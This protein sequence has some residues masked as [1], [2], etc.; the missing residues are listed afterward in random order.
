[1]ASVA[2]VPVETNPQ[3]LSGYGP[4]FTW[5][6]R[7]WDGTPQMAYDFYTATSKMIKHKFPAIQAGGPA[8]GASS[9]E[10]PCG[11]TTQ[12]SQTSLGMMWIKDF[13]Q[14][15]KAHGAPLDLFSFHYG[16]GQG[17]STDSVSFPMIYQS[18]LQAI[19]FVGGFWNIPV[20]THGVQIP[21]CARKQKCICWLFGGGS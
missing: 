11:D 20:A 5:G 3:Q 21:F 15:V 16:Q 2:A 19:A 6:S 8:S 9:S 4:P 18:Y 14:N 17:Q 12:T 13:L 1:M 7:Y 10:F